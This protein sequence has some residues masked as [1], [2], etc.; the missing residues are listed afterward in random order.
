MQPDGLR[1]PRVRREAVLPGVGESAS[2]CPVEPTLAKS[3]PHHLIPLG[4]GHPAHGIPR[5]KRR[6]RD[7]QRVHRRGQVDRD[8]VASSDVELVG[9]YAVDPVDDRPRPRVVRGGA[10]DGYRRGHCHGHPLGYSGEPALLVQDEGS[11]GRS[12]GEAHRV[13]AAEAE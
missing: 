9:G 7:V 12:A 1:G 11:G 10:T 3:L 13:C 6:R 8:G 5:R 2:G 4:E